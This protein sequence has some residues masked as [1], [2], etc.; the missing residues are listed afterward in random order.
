[1][2]PEQGLPQPQRTWAILTVFFGLI[3][4]VLD[5]S[6][7]NIALPS[8]SRELQAD[9]S[10]TIWVVN[11]YQL[12]VTVCLLPLS[13]LGDILGYKRVY[14]AGLATFLL[15]SLL[16]ALAVNLPML[17]AARVL[18]GIGGAGIMS[19]NT[20]LVRFI[21][22]PTRLGRGIGLNALVVGVTIA[23]GPSLGALILAVASWKWLFAVNVPVAIVALVLSRTSLPATPPQP[24][25]FDYRSALLSALV[26]GMFILGVD[27]LGHARW[28]IAGAAGMAAAV[29]LG[30]LLVRRQHGRPAPLVPVDLFSS[31]S[32][33]LAVGT[34]FCSFMTQML[35][36]IALP[37]YLEYQLGRSLQETGL[38]ITPWP[39]MVA[40]MA[41]V[42]G[43]L[44]DRYPASILAGIG[45]AML[46]GG[47]VGLATLG[48]DAGSLDIVWRMAMC[49][50]GFGFFQSPNNRA[51]IGATPPERSGGAS[52]AQATTRL[53]GQTSGT[54]V[55]ALLFSLTPTGAARIA[56]YLAAVVAALGA[57][58][59]LSRLRDA[60]GAEPARGAVEPDA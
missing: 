2:Q 31:R 45:L 54:A 32:F 27:G 35:A 7:A 15:G 25:E 19:V 49:G 56:L 43:R 38:L 17:V 4:A 9:P 10:S 24:R 21:Y 40:V 30:W 55:V 11:A 50:T 34:S 41:T 14:R 20:A 53:L 1:M 51:M 23:V 46:A 42:S 5:G 12:T 36:F 59:S 60:S 8:I 39:L 13:S 6:I 29:M 57:L 28:R 16:C 58:I 37:F 26:F 48:P 18:Q 22:P 47:L 52:G 44:S 33:T 3:M